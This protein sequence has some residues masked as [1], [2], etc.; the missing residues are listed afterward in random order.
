M[1]EW[2]LT[3]AALVLAALVLRELCGERLSCRARY[4]LWLPVLARL[5][6][7]VQL[8][9]ANWGVQTPP[10]PERVTQ[11][12]IYVLPVAHTEGDTGAGDPYVGDSFGYSVPDADGGGYT[13]YAEKWSVADVLRAVWLM[14]AVTLAA[15]LLAS[16][17]RFA[18]RLRRV[19]VPYHADAD[20]MRVYVAE[21]LPSPCLV[22][23]LRPAVY[24]TPEATQDERTL[25]HVLAHETTHR[26]HWDSLWSTLRLAALCLH[27]YDPLVWRAVVVSKHDGELACDEATLERL[28]EGERSA[29]GE[30][31]LRMVRAKPNTRE[32]LSL[33]TSMTAGKRPM[34]A[35]IETIAKH[36]RTHALALALMLAALLGATLFAFSRN[37]EHDVS[38][39][40]NAAKSV[41]VEV[42]SSAVEL[43]P[44]TVDL[45]LGGAN[46]VSARRWDGD[47]WY[48]YIPAE[49]WREAS[50]GGN[51]RWISSYDTGSTL[52]IREAS[53]EER[54]A[55]RPQLAPGQAERWVEAPDGRVWLVWT[56]YDPELLIHS[57]LRGLEPTVLAAM[58]DSFRIVGEA[59]VVRWEVDFDGDGAADKLCLD[60]AKL[61]AGGEAPFWVE[62][63]DGTRVDAGSTATAHAG[64]NT[65]AIA[66]QNGNTYLLF[67]HPIMF[68]GEAEYRYSLAAIKGGRFVTIDEEKVT[69]S[70]NPN[71]LT[72]NNAA[73]M[74]R[75]RERANEVWQNSRLLFT[76]D[77]EVLAH[78]Y[79]AAT[80]VRI[81]TNGAYQI[82]SPRET[83]RYQETMQGL[84]D[85]STLAETLQSLFAATAPADTRLSLYAQDELQDSANGASALMAADYLAEL[86]GIAWEPAAPMDEP[87]R[88]RDWR[89]E[90]TAPSWQLTSYQEARK[91]CLE[92]DG[93][94][95]WLA[96][97]EI[98]DRQY[99]W[100]PYA[101]LTDWYLDAR[102]AEQNR[103]S[104]TPLTREELK[105]WRA[106]LATMR[107]EE[108]NLVACFFSS[109]YADVRDLDLCEF[110]AY[111]PL[112]E[113]TGDEAEFNALHLDWE[114][115]DEN[116]V[117]R[118]MTRD[119]MP[120]PVRRYRVSRINDALMQY[121]GV[122]L[123]DL[124]TDW[125]HDER[126]IYAPEYDAFY[127]FTSDFGPGVFE[128]RYGERDGDAVTLWS[129]SAILRLRLTD[130]GWHIQSHLPSEG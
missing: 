18:R 37:S 67:Y 123:D 110:L 93:A 10:M 76:T 59:S 89:I 36:P 70:A 44:K 45:S 92:T 116:G 39:Q 47:G 125:R 86:S 126:M 24:L 31:L 54:Q 34:R 63:S 109:Y 65:V 71:R 94:T 32:L 83:L 98:P 35:R 22:G 50:S 28:G 62:C 33:S 113:P 40:G 17:L 107:G 104:G 9:T 95:R 13:K 99:V 84:V 127:N 96:A 26:R 16:N 122:T 79:D 20:G 2:A 56:Q 21:G 78:L 88:A 72:E 8:F 91:L 105:T 11:P 15:V 4:A 55:E 114:I 75:F 124:T 23:V 111:C 115:E 108:M 101:K 87:E 81:A 100:L 43:P 119:R 66:E 64:W 49:G 77:R 29:Y 118:P 80:G 106:A 1:L 48:V 68:Q 19:R 5:L 12:S 30:T 97:R 130:G 42:Q 27:W 129:D 58:A 117:R 25:R 41:P 57:D 52:L 51:A 103:G 82:T 7:P 53:R 128:A 3:S 112:S 60:A 74:E 38:E 102:T 14:G 61:A 46:T 6:I 69:F 120:V 90:L 85:G 121:A 73:A